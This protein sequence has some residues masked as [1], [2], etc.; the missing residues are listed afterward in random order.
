MSSDILA[1]QMST[2]SINFV[3]AQ[4]GWIFKEDRKELVA[5]QYD[6][7]LY[8]IN[9]INGLGYT[10][11]SLNK[12]QFFFRFFWI[13][14][15]LESRKRRE[16]L[17][18]DDLQKNK[19]IM[20]SLKGLFSSC[21]NES[22]NFE[23]KNYFILIFMLCFVL[24][25]IYLLIYWKKGGQHAPSLD[26]N[27]EIVRKESLTPPHENIVTWEEYINAEPGEYPTLGRQLV[28]KESNKT[29]RATVAMVSLSKPVRLLSVVKNYNLFH[30]TE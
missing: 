23:I 2:K 20:E 8:T 12:L 18:R 30:C 21:S 4:T 11:F 27:G 6:C 3:R 16:H 1:A 13:G 5:G 10:A 24:I 25:Y 14:L 29:F 28:Y 15:I 7:E 19:A 22:T 9:G 26:Q 17:S